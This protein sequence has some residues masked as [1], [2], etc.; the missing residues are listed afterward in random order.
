MSDLDDWLLRT[1]NSASE[2]CAKNPKRTARLRQNLGLDPMPVEPDSAALR[3]EN[4]R[5]RVELAATYARIEHCILVVTRLLEERQ[6]HVAL[7]GDEAPEGQ[8]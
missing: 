6:P 8:T 3:A 2:E 1:L 5:L 4:A 7:H